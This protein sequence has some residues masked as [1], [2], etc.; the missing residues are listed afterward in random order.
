MKKNILLLNMLVMLLL[1]GM[2]SAQPPVPAKK[3]V[4]GVDWEPQENVEVIVAEGLR[5]NTVDSLKKFLDKQPP[6]TEVVWD[7]GCVRIGNKPMLSTTKEIKDLSSYLEKRG[8][9][10]VLSPAG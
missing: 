2:V 8:I 6:G 10:L 5:F 1:P 3:L 4:L 9:K 7:P